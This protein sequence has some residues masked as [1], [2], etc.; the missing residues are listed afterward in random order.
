MVFPRP[1][2]P[3]RSAPA[4]CGTY[5]ACRSCWMGSVATPQGQGRIRRYAA[6]ADLAAQGEPPADILTLIEGWLLL[7]ALLSD[8][9]RQILHIVVP[10]DV[11]VPL[12]IGSAGF[13]I[14]AA[15]DAT[16]CAMPMTAAT[17][18]PTAHPA[19]LHVLM[20]AMS[21]NAAMAYEH[22][23]AVGRRNARERVALLLVQLYY[24][25]RRAMI[26]DHAV[27]IPLTQGVLADALGLTAVHVNRTLKTLRADGLIAYE[28]GLLRILDPDRLAAAACFDVEAAGAWLGPCP[29]GLATPAPPTARRPPGACR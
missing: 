21:R 13:G 4:S 11:V 9:R 26:P 12:L 14:Q 25:C 16:V 15:T 20:K 2:P 5:P 22:L 23:T 28:G 19:G 17:A 1:R 7:S 10:G 18:L 27:Q 6:G 8:G 24:R 29:P 3:E